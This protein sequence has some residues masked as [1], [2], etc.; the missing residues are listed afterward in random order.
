MRKAIIIGAIE[1][2]SH[3]NFIRATHD[4]YVLGNDTMTVSDG[5]HT[6]D[7]LYD[8]RITLFVALCKFIA[9]D[10]NNP[11]AVRRL[12]VWRSKLHGDGTMFKDQFILGIGKEKGKQITY[13]LPLERWDETEFAETLEKGPEFDGHSPADVLERLKQL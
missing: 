3:K 6:F 2:E 5:F 10:K 11:V 4:F 13:H 8:H 1:V 7:E 12:L 9:D